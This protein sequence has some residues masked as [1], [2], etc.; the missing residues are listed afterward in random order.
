M[1]HEIDQSINRS[2][3]KNNQGGTKTVKSD[4]IYSVTSSSTVIGN[5]KND[6]LSTVNN[7]VVKNTFPKINNNSKYD[8]N[9]L[10]VKK[11]K[12]EK[13]YIEDEKK[14]QSYSIEA[15]TFFYRLNFDDPKIDESEKDNI[16]NSLFRPTHQRIA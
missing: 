12:D 2:N 5:Q 9:G 14:S 1:I 11:K 4:R 13:E 6:S 7:V 16:E 8:S 3:L 10:T 15:V